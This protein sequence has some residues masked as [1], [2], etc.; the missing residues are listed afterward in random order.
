MFSVSE[1]KIIKLNTKMI[2]ELLKN[3]KPQMVIFFGF[4]N[5]SIIDSNEIFSGTGNAFT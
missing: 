2:T 5:S 1:K 4:G 3:S